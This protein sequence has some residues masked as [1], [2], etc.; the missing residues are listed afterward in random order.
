MNLNINS[1]EGGNMQVQTY[2]L[3]LALCVTVG[4]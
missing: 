4:I 2:D 1:K 3:G